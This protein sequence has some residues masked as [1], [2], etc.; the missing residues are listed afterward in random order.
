MDPLNLMI[1]RPRRV[2]DTMLGFYFIPRTIDKLRAELPGGN[3]GPYLNHERGLS[4]YVVRSLG[5]AMSTFRDAVNSAESEDD[6]ARWL[7]GRIDV[8]LAPA[9]NAKLESF[10]VERMTL[11]DQAL[12]REYH[13]VAQRRPNL[14]KLLDI[15]DAD[16]EELFVPVQ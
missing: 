16:D 5:L 2:R 3:I 15:I 1:Q 6:V 7:A 9:L 12:L 10:V 4:A 14:T 8:D 11:E 13:P